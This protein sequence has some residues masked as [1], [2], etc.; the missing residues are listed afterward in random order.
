MESAKKNI[1]L[2]TLQN[3]IE[4]FQMPIAIFFFFTALRKTR[5]IKRQKEGDGLRSSLYSLTINLLL[6]ENEDDSNMHCHKIVKS[7]KIHV[8]VSC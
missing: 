8:K 3:T 2:S 5:R 6:C 7:E 1:Q 4:C